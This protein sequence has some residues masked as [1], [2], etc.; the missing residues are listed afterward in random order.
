MLSLSLCVFTFFSLRF[1]PLAI[2]YC[3]I[4][5]LF[6]TLDLVFCLLLFC[7]SQK[8]KFLFAH[9]IAAFAKEVTSHASCTEYIGITLDLQWLVPSDQGPSLLRQNLRPTK[10]ETTH[11]C[12]T[13]MQHR[14]HDF[15]LTKIEIMRSALRRSVGMHGSFGF[16]PWDTRAY[17]PCDI[18]LSYS[19]RP[20]HVQVWATP[21]RSCNHYKSI[22]DK[23]EQLLSAPTAACFV[24]KLSSYSTGP[25]CRIQQL[26]RRPY[27]CA[28]DDTGLNTSFPVPPRLPFSVDRLTKTHC[29]FMRISLSAESATP[30]VANCSLWQ[31]FNVGTVAWRPCCSLRHAPVNCAFGV[32]L[33]QINAFVAPRRFGCA[34]NMHTVKREFLRL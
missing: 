6:L 1:Q 12:H 19:T 8:I 28:V 20:S 10:P 2:H 24:G 31:G 34:Y 15:N 22:F 32:R 21:T 30:S 17:V 25:L 16:S 3:T 27:T 33:K 11:A 5:L 4:A 29:K 13:P 9:H 26:R 23:N 14:S 7:I 18:Y